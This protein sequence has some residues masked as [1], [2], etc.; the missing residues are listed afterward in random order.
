MS[1]TINKVFSN[2][3][4]SDKIGANAKKLILESYTWSIYEK[5][6]SKILM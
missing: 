2:D 4:D 5:E 3:I 1:E 6:L